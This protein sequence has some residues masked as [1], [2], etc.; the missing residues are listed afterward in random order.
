MPVP[1]STARASAG[2]SA[3]TGGRCSPTGS[4]RPRG[5]STTRWNR[6]AGTSTRRGSGCPA[7]SSCDVGAT[8]AFAEDRAR[9]HVEQRAPR[10]PRPSR[11]ACRRCARRRPAGARVE[12]GPRA[13]GR[14]KIARATGGRRVDRATIGALA[15]PS[16]RSFVA[17]ELGLVRRR[18][19]ASRRSSAPSQTNRCGA[20]CEVAL[21][22]GPPSSV[23]PSQ[24][25]QR[26][27]AGRRAES[28]AE[29]E[30]SG[31][32]RSARDS[33]SSPQSRAERPVDEHG[34]V[35]PRR[36]CRPARWREMDAVAAVRQRRAAARRTCSVPAARAV[37]RA[38]RRCT[39]DRRRGVDVTCAG[40]R[41]RQARRSRVAR[42]RRRSA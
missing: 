25:P 33:A 23:L 9:R 1:T 38:S 42:G 37:S 27:C 39:P 17:V 13:A 34:H 32:R 16:A 18:R 28:E 6:A 5:A 12:P 15:R 4:S 7:G 31:R 21:V 10:S 40:A 36:A 24:D 3:S 41:E 19:R 8:R 2:A 11:R 20:G 22:D 14:S 26:T 35:R 30:S 29:V